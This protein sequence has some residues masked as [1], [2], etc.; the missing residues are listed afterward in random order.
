MNPH[1]KVVVRWIET[2]GYTA[3]L[4]LIFTAAVT[5]SFSGGY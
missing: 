2:V 5:C 3:I 4:L 1:R